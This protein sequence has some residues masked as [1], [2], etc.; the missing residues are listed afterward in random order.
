[1]SRVWIRQRLSSR[2]G[3][4][5]WYD[6]PAGENWDQWQRI[7]AQAQAQ[8]LL[9]QMGYMFRYHDGYCKIAEWVPFGFFGRCVCGSG[10]YVHIF[11]KIAERN[12]FCASGWGIF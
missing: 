3:K 9:I 11:G 2:A 4:H 6:K 1:M 10:A 8:D 12:C 5:A 7:I